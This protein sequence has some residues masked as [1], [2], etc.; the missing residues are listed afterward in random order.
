[1]ELELEL[2][3]QPIDKRRYD[4]IEEFRKGTLPS[5]LLGVS[6]K[7]NFIGDINPEWFFSDQENSVQIQAISCIVCGE[8][9]ECYDGQKILPKITCYDLDHH[10]K[11]FKLKLQIRFERYFNYCVKGIK[12]YHGCHNHYDNNNE[13][14]NYDKYL[15]FVSCMYDNKNY[16]FLNNASWFDKIIFDYL[17]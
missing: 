3:L 8:F 10:V 13:L 15:Y 11:T 12:C 7:S 2:E 1:M 4:N 17:W 9:Q 5:I 16:F 6:R 14:N